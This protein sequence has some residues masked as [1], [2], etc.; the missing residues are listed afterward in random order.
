MTA[1]WRTEYP[2]SAEVV[3]DGYGVRFVLPVVA[4][5]LN[6]LKRRYGNQV[7]AAVRKYAKQAVFEALLPYSR[8][9]VWRDPQRCSV[10]YTVY[11]TRLLDLD[12]LAGG[13]KPVTD[14]LVDCGVLRDDS[15]AWAV[16]SWEQVQVPRGEQRT[17][18]TVMALDP[19]AE[20]S[21]RYTGDAEQEAEA[22]R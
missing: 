11:R 3:E 12:N 14:A 20:R 7:A 4:P 8:G 6:E 21:A 16:L 1:R 9:G 22:K 10:A 18:I 17:E 19:V 13:T 5:S 15:P 2:L